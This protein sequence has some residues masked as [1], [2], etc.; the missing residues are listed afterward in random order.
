MEP[1]YI[2]KDFVELDTSRRFIA[3]AHL[4]KVSEF[5]LDR[6]ADTPLGSNLHRVA[7]MGFAAFTFEAFL[8]HIGEHVVGTREWTIIERKLSPE[9]KVAILGGR[10]KLAV[11]WSAKPWTDVRRLLRMRNEIAHGRNV[12]LSETQYHKPGAF[13][14]NTFDFLEPPWFSMKAREVERI[15]RSAKEAMRIL[16]DAAGMPDN[17]IFMG[18][19]SQLRKARMTQRA[20]PKATKTQRK[21]RGPT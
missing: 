1:E 8:N 10:T 19:G 12:E 17:E 13:D 4:W 21:T 7:A 11:T 18:Y 14:P 16:F 9:Q 6:A 5:M 15:T 2:Q 3:Y 20:V